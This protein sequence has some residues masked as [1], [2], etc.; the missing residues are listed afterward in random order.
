MGIIKRPVRTTTRDR[1]G[2]WMQMASGGQYQ[3][4]AREM[5]RHPQHLAMRFVREVLEEYQADEATY[6]FLQLELA[7][8]AIEEAE[9]GRAS[10]GRS[11]E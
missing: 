3:T 10:D 9:S 2:I 4:L 7:T 11:P 1:M 5:L 8:I 6:I